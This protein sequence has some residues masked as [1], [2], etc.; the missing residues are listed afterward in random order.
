MANL[1]VDKIE[2]IFDAT[3][4][5]DYKIIV[6][7]RAIDK[8]HVHE[9]IESFE[10]FGSASLT[11]TILET[12]VLTGKWERF[13]ADG[14]HS[15]IAVHTLGLPFDAKVVRMQED[16]Y[17]NIMKYVSKL[18]N[19]N[20]GWSTLNYL[21]GFDFLNEYAQFKQFKKESGLQITDLQHIFLGSSSPKVSKLFKEGELSFP[22]FDKS[23]ILYNEVCSIK[24]ILPNKTYTR[25]GLY[26]IMSFA[27]DYKRMANAIRRAHEIMDFS[28][29]EGQ[30][31]KQLEKIYQKEFNVKLTI[32]TAKPKT[33]KK[34]TTVARKVTTK[35][36][37]KANNKG[38]KKVAYN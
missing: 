22:N 17:L 25:R 27:G 11:L 23:M 36:N 16:T 37:N 13:V 2:D 5:S 26:Q 28:E 35:V 19:C 21:D 4:Y 38:T 18:N 12:K 10:K 34:A 15:M 30:F 8:K 9:L 29:N 14:N 32:P 33:T 6:G 20:K 1:K 31:L 7:N 24:A 3:N